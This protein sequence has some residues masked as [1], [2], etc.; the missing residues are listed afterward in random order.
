[1]TTLQQLV[2][3]MLDATTATPEQVIA[4]LSAEAGGEE[5]AQRLI[6]EFL[7]EWD[8]EDRPDATVE[9]LEELDRMAAALAEE[10][11]V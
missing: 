5:E 4:S 11:G 7:T 6:D 10:I 9:Q 1:M 3:D 2:D 8:S